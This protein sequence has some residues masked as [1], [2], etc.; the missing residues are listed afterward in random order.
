MGVFVISAYRPK[1]GMEAWLLE[2]LKTHLPIL[3]A[4]GLATDRPSQVMRAKDGTMIEVFEWNSR[5]AIDAA[6]DSA[7]VNAMWKDFEEACEYEILSN[8]PECRELFASFEPV[9]L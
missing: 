5:E 9:D 8:L 2:V 6:H 7:A 3:R 1:E 4:E